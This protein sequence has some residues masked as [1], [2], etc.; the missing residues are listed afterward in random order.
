VRV[1]EE[2]ISSSVQLPED[3]AREMGN[4]PRRATRSR[5]IS[6]LRG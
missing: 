4:N 1:V 5:G 2:E 6:I 3:A